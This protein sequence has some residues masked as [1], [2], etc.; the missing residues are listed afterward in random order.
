MWGH[1]Q[2]DFSDLPA[3]AFGLIPLWAATFVGS[4]PQFCLLRWNC[5]K[6]E[7]ESGAVTDYA[8]DYNA[9]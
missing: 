7:K 8:L 6:T 5:V 3:P 9:D 2:G 1:R 4:T